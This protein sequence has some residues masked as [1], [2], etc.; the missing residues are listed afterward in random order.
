MGCGHFLALAAADGPLPEV[1]TA[2][3]I[4]A[5]RVTFGRGAMSELGQRCQAHGL[6]RVALFTDARL[7][8]LPIV[9]AARRSLATAG[10][11]VVMFDAVRVEPTQDSFEEAARFAAETRPDGF[12][13]V[14]GGSVIDTTK[15]ASLLASYP[16]PVLD[17]AA[18]PI[19][20]GRAVPGALRPHIAC[21][22]T[23][24]TGSEVTGI[25][26]FDLPALRA[27]TGIAHPALRPTEALVD[28]G[29][30]E[31]LPAGVVASSGMDVLAHALESYTAR[32]YVR[33]SRAPLRPMSQG[34]NPHSDV[35][36]REALELLG[37][38]LVRAV[39]DASDVEARTEVMWAATFA[40][41]AFGNAGVHIPH[42]MAYAVAG[43]GHDRGYRADG[44]SEPGLVPHGLSVIL[45]APAVFRWLSPTAPAR[46]L[47]AAGWLGADTRGAAAEDGGELLAGALER[48]LGAVGMPA[49]LTALGYAGR[50]VDALVQ[51]TLPQ[52]R[53]LDN[54]PRSVGAGE[55]AELFSRSL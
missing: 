34:A 16:A 40:G 23:S 8:S 2:F 25:A 44:Y 53:L 39:S 19:G 42:A 30:T 24:G 32:P 21:P 54:A 46:H 27:K 28:P 35:G 6:S 26:I 52:R 45:N 31:T 29:A 36:C 43:L 10:V 1:E 12:V 5:S 37:R 48:L 38:N 33:R 22:T 55:L 13:S 7:A 41:I 18:P 9:D 50:D 49:G 14:G 3:T 17:Y 11:D 51:A 4:E 20:A 15:A 47:E